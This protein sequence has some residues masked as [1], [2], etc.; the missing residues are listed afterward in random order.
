MKEKKRK[1]MTKKRN[2]DYQNQG[3][4]SIGIYS[5]GIKCVIFLHFCGSFFKELL[6]Y[7]HPSGHFDPVTSLTKKY[8]GS[9]LLLDTKMDLY[10]SM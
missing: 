8:I 10:T 1:R 3:R 2:E 4:F 7:V 9:T 5:I 6:L